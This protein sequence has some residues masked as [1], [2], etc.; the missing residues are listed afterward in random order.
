METTLSPADLP[1]PLPDAV[2]VHGM[3]TSEAFAN[4]GYVKGEVAVQY[5]TASGVPKKIV[6]LFYLCRDCGERIFGHPGRSGVC[7]RCSTKKRIKTA[8]MWAGVS[9]VAGILIKMFLV[10]LV[11]GAMTLLIGWGII[12]SNKSPKDPK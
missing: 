3:E 7:K 1:F 6:R 11:A 10:Y 12:H 4:E 2:E 8:A 5:T 9:I